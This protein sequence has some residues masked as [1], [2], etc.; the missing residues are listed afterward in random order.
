MM[1]KDQLR[2]LGFTGFDR[3]ISRGVKDGL[4]YMT[5]TGL[6]ENRF[7]TVRLIQLGSRW[8][9]DLLNIER[10]TDSRLQTKYLPVVT[11]KCVL[12]LISSLQHNRDNFSSK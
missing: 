4:T 8:E 7:I 6:L 9:V 12:A 5:W 3:Y 1:S 10:D 11:L 2:K